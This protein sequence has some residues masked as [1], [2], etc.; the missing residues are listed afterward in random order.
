MLKQCLFIWTYSC[1]TARIKKNE[2]FLG[3]PNWWS[4]SFVPLYGVGKPQLAQMVP[5]SIDIYP[6]LAFCFCPSVS[7]KRTKDWSQADFFLS[8]WPTMSKVSHILS[9]LTLPFDCFAIT[10][11]RESSHRKDGTYSVVLNAK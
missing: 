11:I 6:G 3:L 5:S 7:R 2:V 9:S 8:I 10:C 1:L 4:C